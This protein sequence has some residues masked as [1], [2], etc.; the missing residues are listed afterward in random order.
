MIILKKGEK[1]GEKLP[2]NLK[3]GTEGALPLLCQ[4]SG[5][6]EKYYR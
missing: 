4:Y 1:M 6:I 5:I 2:E 3:V